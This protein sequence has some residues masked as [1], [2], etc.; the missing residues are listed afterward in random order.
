MAGDAGVQLNDKQIATAKVRLLDE[1]E[2]MQIYSEAVG[3]MADT[4]I[5]SYGSYLRAFADW[6]ARRGIDSFKDVDRAVVRRYLGFVHARGLAPNT[7]A[8]TLASIR[9]MMRYLVDTEQIPLALF[10]HI[11]TIRSPRGVKRLP[12]ALSVEQ[13]VAV[14]DTPDVST[15][16]GLR[17][18]A[19]L[20]TLWGVRAAGFGDHLARCWRL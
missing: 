12:H 16:M 2:Q 7:Q 3:R 5:A 11:R 4:T 17:D 20:E 13:A 6:L 9:S 1:V 14:M 18:R 10:Q 15:P 19:M 8:K